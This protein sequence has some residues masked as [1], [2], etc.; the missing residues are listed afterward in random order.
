M[1]THSA[2]F[3]ASSIGAA[4]NSAW[5]R[6]YPPR[7]ITRMKTH[8]SLRQRFGAR[9]RQLRKEKTDLSQEAF[10]DKVGFA[11]SYFGRVET[12]KANPSLDAIQTIAEGL[13]VEVSALF[14][15]D[16]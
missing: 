5:P 16:D 11:R 15:D 1:N 9:V 4:L 6:L 8:T 3:R 12:G 7:N 10:A 13:G 2:T 14:E